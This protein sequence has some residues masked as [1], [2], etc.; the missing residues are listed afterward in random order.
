MKNVGWLFLAILIAYGCAVVAPLLRYRFRGRVGAFVGWCFCADHPG[1][2]I[3]HPV[4]ECRAAGR[5]RLCIGRHHLQDGRVLSPLGQYGAEHR[6]SRLL[7]LLDSVPGIL[8]R[9]S[10]SQAAVAASGEPLAAGSASLRWDRRC[11]HRPPGDQ[12]SIQDRPGPIELCAE[13]CRDVADLRARHRIALA[14][15]VR[16]RTPGRI[17]HNSDYP[18][19][20]PVA[21]C[22]RVLA[23]VQLPDA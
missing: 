18:K 7:P 4:R 23:T 16:A 21:D 13:P 12:S 9:L 3:A 11:H 2:P 1:L 8:R 10:R 20:L 14:S 5:V 15:A 6:P 19:R 22:L 17:R